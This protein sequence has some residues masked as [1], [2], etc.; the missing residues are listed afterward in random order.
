MAST[1]DLCG[2]LIAFKKSKN[3]RT[4]TTQQ[5]RD[6]DRL[7][8]RLPW[9]V[10]RTS[11]VPLLDDIEIGGAMLLAWIE[12]GLE[13]D[14]LWRVLSG[15]QERHDETLNS[16]RDFLMGASKARVECC[17]SRKAF[18]NSVARDQAWFESPKLRGQPDVI[19]TQT[20]DDASRSP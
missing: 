10:P 4:V 5:A 6:V 18:P 11:L 3:E 12:Q 9:L 7:G 15:A 14:V 1:A 13:L 2:W 16:A 20:W 8:W 19:L 17:S